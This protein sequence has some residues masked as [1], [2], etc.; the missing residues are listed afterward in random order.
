MYEN[1]NISLYTCVKSETTTY[2]S[3]TTKFGTK[4]RIGHAFEVEAV[5]H[6]NLHEI[7]ILCA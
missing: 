2:A 6:S 1:V 4:L 5:L 3:L 7:P